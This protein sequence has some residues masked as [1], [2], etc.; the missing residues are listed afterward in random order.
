MAVL[1]T[2]K[3]QWV[4]SCKNLFLR[5]VEKDQLFMPTFPLCLS[6]IVQRR[7]GGWGAADAGAGPA[8]AGLPPL[9]WLPNDAEVC[10]LCLPSLK[11]AT[12]SLL[13]SN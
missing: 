5:A 9:C 12:I 7:E 3:E 4:W 10:L 6:A 8:L 2:L 1:Q 13:R 11:N